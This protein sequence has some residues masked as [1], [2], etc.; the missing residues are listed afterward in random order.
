MLTRLLRSQV[1][2]HVDRALR[3]LSGLQEAH[4][5]RVLAAATALQVQ[6]CDLERD[7]GDSSSPGEAT[8]FISVPT[9]WSAVLKRILRPDLGSVN[10]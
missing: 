1:S 8:H 5:K 10:K 6:V 4:S 2:S 3:I 9:A 7:P